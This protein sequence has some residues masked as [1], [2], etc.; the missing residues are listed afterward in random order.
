MNQVP[1]IHT[2]MC[3]HIHIQTYHTHTFK[4]EEVMNLKG[5]ME[6]IGGAES[7]IVMSEILN[8]T[9]KGVMY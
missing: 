3:V 7:E 9:K 5:S 6:S 4:K 2:C 1:F 8:S